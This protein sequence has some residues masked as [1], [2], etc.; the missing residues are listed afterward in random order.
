[1]YR[2]K[3]D[4]KKQKR[5]LT[6]DYFF[7]RT[8]VKCFFQRLIQIK[9]VGKCQQSSTNHHFVINIDMKLRVQC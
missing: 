2:L 7:Q 1:M 4:E 3:G 6:A 5:S 9:S 8:Q